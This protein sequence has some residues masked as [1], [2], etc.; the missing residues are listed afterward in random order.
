MRQRRARRHPRIRAYPQ[1]RA[2][3]RDNGTMSP[4]DSRGSPAA[5]PGSPSAAR[6][7]SP[8]QSPSP[9][10]A[11]TPAARPGAG[12]APRTPPR[13]ALW[14]LW[15]TPALWSSNYIIARAA[16]GVVSPHG[17]ALGRWGLV[18]LMLVPMVWSDRQAIVQAWRQE[19]RQMLALGAMG[20]WI[21]GAF[22][23]LGAQATSATNIGLIYAATPVG[24]AV[25]GHWWLGEH[26][27]ARQRVGMALAMLGVLVVI[28]KGRLTTLS[29]AQ[30]SAGD[31]W[32]AAAALSWVG[33]SV[34]QQRWPSSLAPRQRLAG[35]TAGGLM[36]LL[37]FT[38]LEWAWM[39]PPPMSWSAAGL[40]GLA[41]LL[42]GLFS[43][44]AYAY[45][46]RELGVARASLVLYM[47]P[48]YAAFTAWWLLGEAPQM[49]HAIGALLILPSIWLATSR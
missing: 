8:D 23:Y 1:A 15:V 4:S 10:P 42:P 32:I 12:S 44:L 33:Y 16:P 39:P 27:P 25:V 38:A 7:P 40:I 37:P 35:I 9:A 45:M 17:L 22:V 28:S 31:L 29:E 14:L 47:A 3:R 34:L 2:A 48:L 41:A 18:L 24:I 13:L 30:W 11:G 21:C 6:A 5:A 19:W 46:L 36:V 49:H 43:Y 26:A 20:M